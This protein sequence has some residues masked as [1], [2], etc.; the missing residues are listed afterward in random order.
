MMPTVKCSCGQSVVIPEGGRFRCPQ[1]GEL[2]VE[3]QPPPSRTP[4][5][6]ALVLVSSLVGYAFW[7][8]KP[9]MDTPGAAVKVGPAKVANKGKSAHPKPKDDP[10]PDDPPLMK[11]DPPLPP[12]KPE[13]MNDPASIRQWLAT[14]SRPAREAF[15]AGNDVRAA[16][17]LAQLQAD[18]DRVIVGRRVTWPFPVTRVMSKGVLMNRE[19][20]NPRAGAV[21]L[22]Q[23]HVYLEL[24]QERLET[25]GTM[26]ALDFIEVADNPALLEKINVG[27]NVRVTFLI[28][29]AKVV[30]TSERHLGCYL[31]ISGISPEFAKEPEKP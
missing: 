29:A 12:R 13:D 17:V 21:H 16:K 10:E 18:V 3:P 8:R 14:V 1:C 31:I 15:G 23:A 4:F 11:Q 27:D 28:D 6:V 30:V 2:V 25:K 26:P 24:S 20:I 19:S 9:S 7:S 22:G 5:F